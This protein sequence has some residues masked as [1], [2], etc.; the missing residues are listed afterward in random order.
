MDVQFTPVST[1][2]GYQLLSGTDLL[3]EP[4]EGDTSPGIEGMSFGKWVGSFDTWFTSVRVLLTPP[5]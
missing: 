4:V 1:N 5:E 2:R 3:S